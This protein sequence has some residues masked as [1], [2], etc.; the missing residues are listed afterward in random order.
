M[1]DSS[2]VKLADLAERY[3]RFQ[4]EEFPMTA[5]MAGEAF[6]GDALLRGAPADY[7]RRA[8]WGRE[9]LIE[10]D[11]ISSAA[12]DDADR[13]T[14]AL[15]R[16]ELKELVDTVAV[17]AH[18]RPS[19]YPLGPDFLLTSWARMTSLSTIDDA[20]RYVAR[21]RS[22]PA[23]IDDIC[24]C[25]AAGITAGFRYP[26]LVIDRAVEVGRGMQGLPLDQN[27]FLAPLSAL[28]QRDKALGKILIEGRAVIERQIVPAFARYGDFV[29]RDLRAVAR[30]DL[31]ITNDMDGAAYYA[32]LIEQN[33]TLAAD[34]AE[35][36]ALGLAEIERI[37]GEMLEAAAE[38]GFP[39]DLDGF[40]RRLMTDNSQLAENCEALRERI[41]ILSK[42]IDGRIPEFF[43]RVPR[44]TYT[45]ASIPEAIAAAMPPAY[46]QPNPAD[47]SAA[48]VHWITSIPSKLPR[49]MQV[50]VALH[51]AWPGHLMHLALIQEMESLPAFRRHGAMRYS[52]C[53]E[54]W[55][56]YCERLGEDMG[57][58]DSPEKRYGRLEMEIWR[59][60]RLVTDTGLHTKGWTREQAI[61]C[62]RRHVALPVDIVAAE[63]DRYVALPGQALGYQ[64]GNLRFRAI[65]AEAEALL[66][67]RFRIRD[68]HDALMAAGPVTLDVLEDLMRGWMASQ[69]VEAA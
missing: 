3:W 19:L 1:T 12:L 22:I 8:D 62:F 37:E 20:K 32:F 7:R 57:L 60:V 45:V 31:A 43:G 44:S 40:R 64:L 55:A 65:R 67:P 47:R 59:A 26:R 48:G 58:Y 35:I 46:A 53:L 29:D 41:E 9:A 49:Y 11:A 63:V 6:E 24:A 66:G 54:G 25:L 27:P 61:D 39:D 38:A 5:I 13:A 21:L 23:A 14:H 69:Q 2:S 51:E 50:P 10:W 28:Q 4:C 18:L 42:R 33:T 30:D 56:L 17:R 36:H 16:R 52:A 15:L 68:F 34:P